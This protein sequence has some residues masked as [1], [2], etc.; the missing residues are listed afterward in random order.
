MSGPLG[1][2]TVDGLAPIGLEVWALSG[3]LSWISKRNRV[4]LRPLFLWRAK[5]CCRCARHVAVDCRCAITVEIASSVLVA[6]R[7]IKIR[8]TCT[9]IGEV[10]LEYPS[11]DSESAAASITATTMTNQ[12]GQCSVQFTTESATAVS[13]EMSATAAIGNRCSAV[14]N[15]PDSTVAEMSIAATTT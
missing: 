3:L 10:R 4:S 1:R 2:D 12:S 5:R 14:A 6:N 11:S 8:G 7:I 13:G 9:N 15:A